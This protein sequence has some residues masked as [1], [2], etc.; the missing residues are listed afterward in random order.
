[1]V[2]M[3]VIL[4]Y[5]GEVTIKGKDTRSK[6]QNR[7]I[8][9]LKDLLNRYNAKL[10]K[11]EKLGGYVILEVNGKEE[12][13][14]V[15]PKLFGISKAYLVKE[16]T[17]YSLSELKE[18]IKEVYCNQVNG[19]KFGVRIRKYNSDVSKTELEKYIGKV[20][21]DECSGVVNL[22]NPDVW[23]KMIV[24]DNN[25]YMVEREYEGEGGLPLGSGDKGLSLISGGIDSSLASLLIMKR[26]NPLDFVHYNLGG[27]REFVKDITYFLYFN[28]S[29]GYEPVLYIVNFVP[30]LAKILT[31]FK[32]HESVVALKRSMLI[33]SE[34]LAK[35]ARFL[36]T[37]DSLNQVSSQTATNILIEEMGISLPIFR[38]L[39]A[40][41]KKDIYLFGIKYKLPQVNVKVP[42][43]CGISSSA[44]PRVNVN[45]IEK[46]ESLRDDI[47]K[48]VKDA[49]EI[50][51]K[52]IRT[53]T[54]HH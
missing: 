35:E 53:H 4:T 8:F 40:F 14:D 13:M 9:N 10:L 43:Y 19:K 18:K 41:D 20:L 29:F 34:M 31:T 37:G 6:M 39:I 17:Q 42:E 12:I 30:L 38:P 33:A 45:V 5:A 49:E 51:V 15:L 24:I 7:L 16:G 26:G 46:V 28:Y 47:E 27:N 25:I 3:K 21:K 32:K 23:I 54:A 22:E 48:S 11:F 44:S 52:E 36:V 1:M 50:K 2:E